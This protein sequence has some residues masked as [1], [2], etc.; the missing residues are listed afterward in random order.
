M[1][2]RPGERGGVREPEELALLES[3]LLAALALLAAIRS[4]AAYTIDFGARGGRTWGE[5]FA[6]SLPGGK[7]ASKA[8]LVPPPVPAHS[9]PSRWFPTGLQQPGEPVG[10]VTLE[11]RRRAPSPGGSPNVPSRVLVLESRRDATLVRLV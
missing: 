2:L 9:V 1:P 5:G 4:L 6:V 7:G 3:L 11:A 8:T 10:I